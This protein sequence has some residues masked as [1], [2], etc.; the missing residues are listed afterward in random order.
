[1]R[2]LCRALPTPLTIFMAMTGFAFAAVPAVA[3]ESVWFHSPSKNIY[4]LATIDNSESVVDCEL[5]E[6][7]N[8]APVRAVP[9]D[10]DL[11]WGNRFELKAGGESYLTCTGDTLRAGPA[12]ALPYGESIDYEGITC[13]SEKSGIE[14]VN[15]DGHGFKISKRPPG[16]LLSGL[17]PI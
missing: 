14:C 4:C 12:T 15:E 11:E 17:A 3:L 8:G 7:T 5:V 2:T 6:R 1:M 13:S 10:C 16:T 9:S